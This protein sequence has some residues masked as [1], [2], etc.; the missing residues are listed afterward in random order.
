MSDNAASSSRPRLQFTL[1]TLL[2]MTAVIAAILAGLVY[3]WR[4]LD[5]FAGRPFERA[6]WMAH[7]GHEANNPRAAMVANL[8]AA[9]LL[10]GK[11]RAEVLA[12]LGPPTHEDSGRLFYVLGAWSRLRLDDDYLYV[13]FDPQGRLTHVEV[14]QH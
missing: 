11:S 9:Y 8:R 2:M 7:T 10:P 13:H 5:P 3:A 12:L 6:V 1:R 4:A 14:H